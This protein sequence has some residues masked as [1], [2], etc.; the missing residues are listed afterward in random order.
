MKLLDAAVRGVARLGKSI[1]Q[2]INGVLREAAYLIGI[3]RER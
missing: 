1:G 3:A 2:K